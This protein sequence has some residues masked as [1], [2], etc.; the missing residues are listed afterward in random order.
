MLNV[1]DPRQSARRGAAPLE[2]GFARRP[3]KQGDAPGGTGPCALVIDEAV[4]AR[5]PRC[6]QPSTRPHVAACRLE[7]GAGL[8]DIERRT[9]EQLMKCVPDA[10]RQSSDGGHRPETLI[11]QVGP[12]R[13]R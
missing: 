12:Q 4:I 5:A 9:V 7:F 8:G 13:S 11:L 2:A 1:A 10:E 6:N 3:V